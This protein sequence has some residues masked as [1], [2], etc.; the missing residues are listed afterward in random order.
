[1]GKRKGKIGTLLERIEECDKGGQHKLDISHLMLPEFPMEAAVV[2]RISILI[3]TKNL[4]DTVPPLSN[5]K[6]LTTLD[7]SRNHITTLNGMKLSH[8]QSLRILDV[9][10]NKLGNL[11]DDVCRLPVLEQLYVHRNQLV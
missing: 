4:F 10:R 8:L 2:A 9:S 11:P 7:L 5:F 6:A 1:M 3:A